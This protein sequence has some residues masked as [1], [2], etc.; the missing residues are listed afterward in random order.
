MCKLSFRL[1]I[2]SYDIICL[3]TCLNKNWLIRQIF[4]IV[5]LTFILENALLILELCT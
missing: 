5:H 3:I 2:K 1:L 4:L